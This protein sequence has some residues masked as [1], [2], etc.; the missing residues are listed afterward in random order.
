MVLS[1]DSVDTQYVMAI[2]ITMAQKYGF[3]W[4]HQGFP[5]F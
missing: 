1:L 5:R 3:L 2:I 4:T